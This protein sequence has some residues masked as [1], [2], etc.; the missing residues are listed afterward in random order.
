MRVRFW[1]LTISDVLGA[2]YPTEKVN[3]WDIKC[4]QGKYEH[5]GVFWFKYGTPYDK[6]PVHGLSMY[7]NDVPRPTVEKV[8]SFLQSKF[9]GKALYRQAR[10]FLQGSQEFA[11]ANSIG[12]LANELSLQF[13]APVELTVEFEKATKEEIEGSFKLPAGKALP[14]AGPD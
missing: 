3:H 2:Q 10:A 9:G 1:R 7:F 14:V 12:S 8:V 13:N 5:F 6:E 11:D 4:M